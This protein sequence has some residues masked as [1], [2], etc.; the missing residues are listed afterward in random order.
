MYHYPPKGVP[1]ELQTDIE[2]P[3]VKAKVISNSDIEI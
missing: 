1:T 2:E 3:K